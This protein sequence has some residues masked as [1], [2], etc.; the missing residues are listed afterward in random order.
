MERLYRVRGMKAEGVGSNPPTSIEG[1]I[2]ICTRT[3][4]YKNL[5][6]EAEKNIPQERSTKKH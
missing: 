2:M 3:R 1:I 4:T 5:R 6:K